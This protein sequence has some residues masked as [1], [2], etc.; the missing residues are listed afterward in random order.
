[1]NHLEVY[2]R[3]HL[4]VYGRDHLAVYGRESLL[5]TSSGDFYRIGIYPPCCRGFRPCDLAVPWRLPAFL[6]D[7]REG[8]GV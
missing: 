4:E 7:L 1:M 2:G 5:Y 3:D 8:R 6:G